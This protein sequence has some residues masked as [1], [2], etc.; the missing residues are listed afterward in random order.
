MCVCENDMKSDAIVASSSPEL[1]MA[2][3]AQGYLRQLVVEDH[4]SGKVKWCGKVKH[5]MQIVKDKVKEM[6][7]DK[8]YWQKIFSRVKSRAQEVVD[9]GGDLLK[10]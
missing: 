4:L 2:E 10:S 9:S 1:N 7:E 8:E 3:T 6:N 5:K